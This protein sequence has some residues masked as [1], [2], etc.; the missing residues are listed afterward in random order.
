[1]KIKKKQ[2]NCT[3]SVKVLSSDFSSS[4]PDSPASYENM[5]ASLIPSMIHPTVSVELSLT[6]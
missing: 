4:A 5:L 3:W 1:M 6:S 2:I